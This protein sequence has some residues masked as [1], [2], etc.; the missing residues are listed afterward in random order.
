MAD[1]REMYLTLMRE[2]ERAIRI[3]TDAQRKCEELYLDSM[4]PDISL[5]ERHTEPPKPGGRN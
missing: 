1:Y 2:T 5:L 4:N 3:L